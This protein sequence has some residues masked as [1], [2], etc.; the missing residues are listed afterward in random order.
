MRELGSMTICGRYAATRDKRV[1]DQGLVQLEAMNKDE[2]VFPVELSISSADS[3][4][5]EIFVSY[6][7]DISTRVADQTE[8]VEARDKALAGE[9]A[10]ANFLA[11]MS[12]EMRTPLN[13]LLGSLQ[14][15]VGTELNGKQAKFVDVM[16]TSGQML[17]EQVNNVLDISR[18]DAGKVEKFE[19]PFE[20]SKLV[21]EVVT[22]LK[23]MALERG[24]ALS[25]NLTAVD[26]DGAMGDKARLSQIL[27]NLVGNALKFTENGSVEIEAERH[28]GS[29]LVEFRVIDNGI[30]IPNERQQTIFED[31]VTLDT[32]F[33]RKVEGTGLVLGIVRRLVTIL[34]G[35]IGLE[36]E[37]G[38]GS[39]FWVRIPM[40]RVQ[41]VKKPEQVDTETGND[42]YVHGKYSVLIVEDN[43][44]NRLI[45]REMLQGLGCV[46]AEA[47][48]GQAGVECA[49][50]QPYDLIFCDIS[51]PRMDGIEATQQIRHGM[52]PNAK[53]PIIALTAHALPADIAKFRA[54]G[55]N[56]VIV[57]PLTIESLQNVLEAHLIAHN[58][59]ES[60]SL[61]SVL[62][63]E[64]AKEVLLQAGDEIG[65]G[66][67]QLQMMVVDG[68][69]SK[70]IRELAHKLSGVAAV[71]GWSSVHQS[72]SD[73]ENG[74]FDLSASELENLI[75]KTRMLAKV[76]TT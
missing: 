62:G 3:G 42:E 75:K 8:L 72:L 74:A 27:V 47:I 54:A 52:G 15:M 23:P 76:S 9:K 59:I 20:M 51:M 35:E 28:T 24:N 56:E 69:A 50:V 41:S 58:P 4:G 10:K 18:A 45:A 70:K 55:M 16:R 7:R 44:I 37:T 1:V 38:M 61:A 30:G 63:N 60:S 29:D 17:L 49:S 22:S 26:V 34:G 71:V 21:D 43:E 46:V 48:D 65:S 64:K 31:F 25:V 73:I 6:I 11:V 53:T 32:S 36:S 57:K 5:G 39:V 2:N 40:A 14:L 66:L 19:Q 12:H 13:G 67:D 33:T 68:A